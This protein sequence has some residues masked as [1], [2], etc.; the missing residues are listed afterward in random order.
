MTETETTQT[1]AVPAPLILGILNYLR[2]RPYAEVAGGVQSL[3]ALLAE[4]LPSGPEAE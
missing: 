1:V 4:Q 2:G 3:E